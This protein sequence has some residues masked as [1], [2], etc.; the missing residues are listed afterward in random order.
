MSHKVILQ[1]SNHLEK[2]ANN[3][4]S[5]GIFKEAQKLQQVQDLINRHW[6]NKM[7]PHYKKSSDWD[8]KLLYNLNWAV[9]VNI[10]NGYLVQIQQN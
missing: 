7:F 9:D 1:L 5:L 2:K 8:P 10:Q 6:L 4:L 3:L